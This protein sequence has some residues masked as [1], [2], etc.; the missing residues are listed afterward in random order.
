MR[1]HGALHPVKSDPMIIDSD[2]SNFVHCGASQVNQPF[3]GGVTSK[4]HSE[5]PICSYT[6]GHLTSDQLD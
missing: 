5:V 4:L 2:S 1:H 3:N 6:E